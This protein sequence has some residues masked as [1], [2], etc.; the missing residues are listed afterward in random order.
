MTPE[1]T[2]RLLLTAPMELSAA[3]SLPANRRPLSGAAGSCC[4]GAWPASVEGTRWQ[5]SAAASMRWAALTACRPSP[6][7]K[8]LSPGSAGSPRGR[9][10]QAWLLAAMC[11]VL[12]CSLLSA[13]PS[14]QAPLSRRPA[15]PSARLPAPPASALLQTNTW[16]DIADMIDARAYGSCASLGNTVLAVGGLQSDMQ[17][18]G[19]K[20]HLALGG[21]ARIGAGTS[22]WCLLSEMQQRPG[23][24]NIRVCRARLMDSLVW[25]PAGNQRPADPA[26]RA[27]HSH[28]PDIRACRA[29]GRTPA[30]PFLLVCL[31]PGQPSE[32]C[33]PFVPLPLQTHALLFEAYNAAADTWEHVALPPNANP[34]RSFLAAC[35]LEQ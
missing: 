1:Y 20:Q 27:L 3:M 35:G 2:I 13:N 5:R 31:S 4:L 23:S 32:S 12:L 21:G 9:P 16:R 28:A 8:P 19:G 33:K 15:R 25:L 18:G 22:G 7:A 30:P 6:T 24:G 34:R 10:T 26:W 14:L 29:A 11:R 17:V